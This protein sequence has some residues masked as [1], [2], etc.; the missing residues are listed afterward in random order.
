[1]NDV[2]GI[3]TQP[4]IKNVMKKTCVLALV[5]SMRR[6]IKMQQKLSEF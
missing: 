5:I 4:A 6:Y 1:M 3:T 2:F